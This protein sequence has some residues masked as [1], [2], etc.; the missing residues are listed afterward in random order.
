M[1]RLGSLWEA[2]EERGASAAAERDH[3][4]VGLRCQE[5]S[6][7]DV[8]EHPNA[9]AACLQGEGVPAVCA[10]GYANCNGDP[11]DGCETRLTPEVPSCCMEGEQLIDG[12]F[13]GINN[14]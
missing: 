13:C 5:D 7:L 8:S 4:L 3:L 10:I 11:A 2:I 9:Q 1:E 14:R 12:E 6:D